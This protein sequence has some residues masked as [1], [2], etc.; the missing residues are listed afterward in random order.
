MLHEMVDD[1]SVDLEGDDDDIDAEIA[2][3]RS[4]LKLKVTT[5]DKDEEEYLKNFPRVC[6]T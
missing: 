3:I 1:I 6:N 4:N 5:F 2:R